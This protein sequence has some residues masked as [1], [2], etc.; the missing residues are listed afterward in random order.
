[1][2]P[3]FTVEYTPERSR[4]KTFFR[5]ILAIPH[6]LLMNVWGGVANILTFFQWWIILF[7][8]K[9]NRSITDMQSSWLGYGGRVMSYYTMMYDV[10]PAF[11]PEKGAEPTTYSYEYSESANRLT[12]FFR[13]FILIPAMFKAFFVMIG[14]LFTMLG[15]WFGILFTGRQSKGAFDRLLKTHQYMIRLNAYAMM[16]TDTYPK[17]TV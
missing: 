4:L 16:M 8:G 7:T 2:Q 9:R 5:Y 12:T 13:M 14:T 1:M 6:M 15:T 10:W 17:Y 11:G 3:T